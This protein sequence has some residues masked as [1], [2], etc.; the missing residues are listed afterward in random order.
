MSRWYVLIFRS[1]GE[2]SRS[3]VKP[4]LDMLGK[5]GISVSQ[6]SIFDCCVA[7]TSEFYSDTYFIT[8]IRSSVCPICLS[9]SHQLW[10]CAFKA[11]DMHSSRNALPPDSSHW[12]ISVVNVWRESWRMICCSMVTADSVAILRN[13]DSVSPA[14][15]SYGSVTDGLKFKV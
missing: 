1:A 10:S 4:I 5:G 2:R 11:T 6:T 8:F 12:K 7:C 13:F 15:H 14:K 9:R 3:K